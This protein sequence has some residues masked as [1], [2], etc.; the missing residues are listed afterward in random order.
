MK[1]KRARGTRSRAVCF[2]R[3]NRRACSPAKPLLNTG[4]W[5]LYPGS[6][7]EVSCS[8]RSDSGVRRER[9]EREKRRRKRGNFSHPYPT[10]LFFF[11]AH[12]SLCRPHDLTVDKAPKKDQ[13]GQLF[14]SL[15]LSLRSCPLPIIPLSLSPAKKQR[16]KKKEKK[17][18]ISG[19]LSLG[20][21]S[22][23]VANYPGVR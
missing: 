12:T 2:A 19:Y 4:P 1:S 21:S 18:L 16:S 5:T 10:P 6:R 15:S 23:A 14:P 7:T 3:P 13:Q 20:A 11:S 9:R 22:L 8:R 17:R